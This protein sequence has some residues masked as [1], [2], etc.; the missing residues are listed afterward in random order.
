MILPANLINLRKKKL[1][2]I[3]LF[4]FIRKHKEKYVNSQESQEKQ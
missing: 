3:P 1:K 4:F 2:L